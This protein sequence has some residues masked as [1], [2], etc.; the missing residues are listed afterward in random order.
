MTEPP[1]RVVLDTSAIVVYAHGSVDVGETLA[2]VAAEGGSFGIPELCLIHA[3]AQLGADGWP[4]VELLLA[5]SACVRLDLPQGWT[6]IA[7]I[8]ATLGGVDR[9]VAL[10]SAADL[11]AHLLTAEPETYDE[12]PSVIISVKPDDL[13]VS[14]T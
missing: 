2:E 8:V 4:A 12:F 1:V 7:A 11:G 14:D 13:G 5:H 3:G 6:D 10:F 9:A